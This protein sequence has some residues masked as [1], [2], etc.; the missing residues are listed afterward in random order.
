M[1]VFPAFS[2]SGSRPSSVNSPCSTLRITGSSDW[3]SLPARFSTD[4]T[5]M[6]TVSVKFRSI[7]EVTEEAPLAV[8]LGAIALIF[9]FTV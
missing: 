5:V 1:I 3:N 6:L 4:R 9:S 7:C 2:I 8:I